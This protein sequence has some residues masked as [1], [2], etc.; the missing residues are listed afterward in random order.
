[1]KKPIIL[2]GLIVIIV[3]SGCTQQT[4][5]WNVVI[6]QPDPANDTGWTQDGVDS[7]VEANNKFALDFY[8]NIKEK[9]EGNIFYSPYSI[10][11]ALAM[12]YEGARGQTAEE[13]KSVF[14]FPEDDIRRLP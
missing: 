14:Y 7:V 2:F 5:P 12:T 9:E 11:T 1:M 13:M 3:V 10:S 6:Q 4:D 8:S